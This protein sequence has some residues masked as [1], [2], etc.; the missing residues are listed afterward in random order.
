M[1][2]DSLPG[3]GPVSDAPRAR[4]RS[5]IIAILL[6]VVSAIVS[7]LYLGRPRRALFY[8]CAEVIAVS[9]PIALASVGLWIPGV[10]W[11]LLILIVKAVAV[12]D[13]FRIARRHKDMFDGPWFTRWPALSAV[14]IVLLILPGVVRTFVITSYQIPSS[15]MM[16]TL[17]IGDQFFATPYSGNLEIQRGDVVVFR[18]PPQPDI[19]FIKRVVGVPG[20]TIAY[21]DKSLY[22]N[23]TKIEQ[24]PK[25]RYTASRPGS[26][27]TGASLRGESIDG[28]AYEILIQSGYP[29][30][31]GRAGVPADH[32]FVLGDN[33]DNSRD[34]RYWGTVPRA[35]M[36]ARAVMIWWNTDLPDRAG[37]R[38]R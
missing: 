15:A 32:F 18:Y 35:L 19:L 29:S 38:I 20:D 27:M 14:S 17:L 22:V 3:S 16:P 34:S 12:A 23:G 10:T 13:A 24:V 1:P 6:N 31:D 9:L 7:M 28:R 36:V 21:I 30:V 11:W 5:A 2:G 8:F 37:I 33:R 4:R 25:G 26:K